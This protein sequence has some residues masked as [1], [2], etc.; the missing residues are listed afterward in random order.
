MYKLVLFEVNKVVILNVKIKQTQFKPVI[1][2]LCL[3][4][5]ND[6]KFVDEQFRMK[7]V[8]NSQHPNPPL[9]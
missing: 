3:V 8:R 7:Q 5:N 2:N 4:R 1:R 6:P 9:M